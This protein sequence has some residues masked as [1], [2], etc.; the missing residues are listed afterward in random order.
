MALL[1]H[2]NLENGHDPVAA[3]SRFDFLVGNES[4]SGTFT[5]I[6]PA[7]SAISTFGSPGS[8]VALAVL[9]VTRHSTA[10]AITTTRWLRHYFVFFFAFSS[11][12][13]SIVID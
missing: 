4:A 7:S 8:S 13:M 12:L 6:W 9:T 1:P 2:G 11:D 10:L 3:N 5:S